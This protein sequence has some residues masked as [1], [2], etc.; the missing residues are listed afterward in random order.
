MDRLI[1]LGPDVFVA[2]GRQIARLDWQGWPERCWIAVPDDERAA[3]ARA[4]VE[5]LRASGVGRAAYAGLD[6]ALLRAAGAAVEPA[7]GDLQIGTLTIAD[8][9]SPLTIEEPYRC[10]G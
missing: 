7:G 5:V 4:V 1:A 6:P 10:H 3:D 2:G 9:T 8:V